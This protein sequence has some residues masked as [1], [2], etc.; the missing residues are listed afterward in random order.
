MLCLYIS[1]Q[2]D[3]EPDQQPKFTISFNP[4]RSGVME[5]WSAG[6]VDFATV[7]YSAFAVPQMK[8]GVGWLERLN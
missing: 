2:N 8:H 4:Q 5:Y 1:V 7:A 3:F 6:V